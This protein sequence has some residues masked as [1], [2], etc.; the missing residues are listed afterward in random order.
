M[1]RERPRERPTQRDEVRGQRAERA[2]SVRDRGLGSRS[3]PRARRRRGAPRRSPRRSYVAGVRPRLPLP[4]RLPPRLAPQR[5]LRHAR[6]RDAR[7]RALHAQPPGR[8]RDPAAVRL[9]A[10]RAGG[11]RVLALALRRRVGGRRRDRAPHLRLQPRAPPHR[12]TH[13]PARPPR[14]RTHT[15]PS[16]RAQVCYDAADAD[17]LFYARVA[18][19][20]AP[21]IYDH[22]RG[23]RRRFRERRADGD[24]EDADFVALAKSSQGKKGPVTWS[25]RVVVG[26]RPPRAKVRFGRARLACRISHRAFALTSPRARGAGAARAAR[27]ERSVRLDEPGARGVG[28][29]LPAGGGDGAAG[30]LH[31]TCVT[32]SLPALP[33]TPTPA[34]RRPPLTRSLARVHAQ[35]C[36]CCE[37]PAATRW[38]PSPHARFASSSK[39]PSWRRSPETRRSRRRRCWDWRRRTDS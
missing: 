37:R 10:A 3:P 38:P 23:V 33:T 11:G 4:P 39:L 5:R 7:G 14:E 21:V 27:A 24:P 26:P 25:P 8:R 18:N 20:T 34:H 28:R 31:S 2:T 17:F 32:L 1:E 16:P 30:P 19:R 12:A 36:I 35:A 9:R 15:P 13:R 22:R 29:G 6:R